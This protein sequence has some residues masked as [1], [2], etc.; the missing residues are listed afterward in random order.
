MQMR[1]NEASINEHS[2]TFSNDANSDTGIS[3]LQTECQEFQLLLKK[4]INFNLISLNEYLLQN[5]QK[6]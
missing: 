6:T 2:Q 5:K 4:S 1:K 3:K